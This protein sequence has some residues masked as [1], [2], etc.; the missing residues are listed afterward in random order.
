MRF[1]DD[2]NGGGL[3]PDAPSD[4]PP[5]DFGRRRVAGILKRETPRNEQNSDVNWDANYIVERMLCRHPH[6][7]TAFWWWTDGPSFE[8]Y[9]LWRRATVSAGAGGVRWRIC[10]DLKKTGAANSNGLLPEMSV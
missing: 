10:Y 6:R 5:A 1:T 7:S 3:Q 8:V 9:C 2:E 4:T